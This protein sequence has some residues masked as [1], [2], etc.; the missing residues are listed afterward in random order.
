MLRILL[1]LTAHPD[2]RCNGPAIA[3]FY[4]ISHSPLRKAIHELA[5]AGFILSFQGK[6]GGIVLAKPPE[7]ISLLDIVALSDPDLIFPTE[8]P[9]EAVTQSDHALESALNATNQTFQHALN[10]ITI[11][12]VIACV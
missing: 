7:N 9:I 8:P 11:A 4:G 1:Y 6:N 2:A 10:S 12:D 3:A 5:K